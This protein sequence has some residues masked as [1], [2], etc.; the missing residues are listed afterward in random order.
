MSK[1]RQGLAGTSKDEQGLVG[2]C[3]NPSYS[4]LIREK[5]FTQHHF[6]L[7]SGERGLPSTI[8]RKNG[9]GFTILETLIAL[10]ILAVGLLGL[11]RALPAGLKASKLGE[12]TT[13]AILLGQQKM[14]ELRYSS[15]SSLADSGS[16]ITFSAPDDNFQ[17]ETTVTD[18]ATDLKEVSLSVWWP[19]GATSQRCVH[20]KTYMANYSL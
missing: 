20:L 6:W 18:P 13:I 16:K 15:W 4:V 5:G 7:K 19:A 1:V 14:E 8:F 10:S 12:D 9:A 17:W 3:A 11:L 2:I